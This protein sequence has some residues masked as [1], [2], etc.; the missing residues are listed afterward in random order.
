MLKRDFKYYQLLIR[1]INREYKN[2]NKTPTIEIHTEIIGSE[3]LDKLSEEE[4]TKIIKGGYS[5][6]NC[7][8]QLINFTD[9]VSQ[10]SFTCIILAFPPSHHTSI[11][12]MYLFRIST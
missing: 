7:Q 3:D 1:H 8:T 10:N 12:T 2:K 5:E 6:N 4:N 9:Y 11:Q